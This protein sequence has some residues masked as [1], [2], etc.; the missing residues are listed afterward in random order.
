MKTVFT[1]A[2]LAT[3]A[4]AQ[5][6]IQILVKT[7]PDDSTAGMDPEDGYGDTGALTFQVQSMACINTVERFQGTN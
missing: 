6:I 3:M 7:D 5:N 4:N 1:L 2:F